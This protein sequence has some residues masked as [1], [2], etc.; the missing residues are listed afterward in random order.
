RIPFNRAAWILVLI[1]LAALAQQSLKVNVDLVN[2]FITA[3]DEHGEFVNNLTRKDF[4]I[5][6]D[7]E[8][9]EI[10]IFE[11][12]RDVHSAIGILLDTSGSTVDILPY[13]RKGLI[14]FARSIAH[15]DEYYVVT[16]GTYVRMI[17]RSPESNAHLEQALQGIRAYGTSL[18]FDAM[19]YG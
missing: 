4:V 10:S 2:V 17:H 9:K 3:Q 11:K 19:L 14:E 12:E 15:P 13:E 7:G 6:E 16:F 5:Y 1:P 8:P 18:L